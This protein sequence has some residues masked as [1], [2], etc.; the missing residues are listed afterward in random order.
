MSCSKIFCKKIRIG[1]NILCCGRIF[2]N[3]N[4]NKNSQPDI[5]IN[6]YKNGQGG[7]YIKINLVIKNRKKNN[8][9][10]QLQCHADNFKF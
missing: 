7:C 9:N 6:F 3:R 4:N 2:F 8:F 1:N 10:Y 5:I